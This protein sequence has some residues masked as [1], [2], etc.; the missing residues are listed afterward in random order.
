MRVRKEAI[1]V[2][3]VML[4]V[5]RPDHPFGPSPKRVD[6]SRCSTLQRHFIVELELRLLLVCMG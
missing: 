6:A 2:Q 5:V 4:E 1:A 3:I